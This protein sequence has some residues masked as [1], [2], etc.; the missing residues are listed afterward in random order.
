MKL[1]K[2]LETPQEVEVAPVEAI[3]PPSD[4]SDAIEV[5]SR[6][7]L[8]QVTDGVYQDVGVVMVPDVAQWMS[9]N[10]FVQDGGC[11]RKPGMIANVL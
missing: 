1:K 4:A 9:D 7:G 6:I 8:T 2:E 5:L 3:E 11:F 10:G